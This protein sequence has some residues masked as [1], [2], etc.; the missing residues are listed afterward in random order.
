MGVAIGIPICGYPS[1]QL[2]RGLMSL[3]WPA[4]PRGFIT[5][6]ETDRPLP[7]DVAHNR[8]IETFLSDKRLEWLLMV[9]ADATLHPKTL[10]R[11]LSWN[12]PVVGALCFTRHC[13]AGPTIYAGRREGD[14]EG[15]YVI[16]VAETRAWLT[17][18]PEMAVN[19]ATVMEPRPDDALAPV[20]FT[21]AHCLLVRRDVLE[22]VGSPWFE[23]L[24]PEGGHGTGADRDFCEKAR[25][26]GFPL[27][28]DRSVLAGHMVGERCIGALDFL[29]WDRITDWPNRRFTVGPSATQTAPPSGNTH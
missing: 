27:Y 3:A 28:V 14:P 22:A 26:A 4:G 7:I 6:G 11:L 10:L 24:L 20:D 12:Q 21:G 13:P 25:R 9:D 19:Q 18:H 1:W 23:R 8:I 17:A 16:R 15:Y 5:A 2:V 29:A